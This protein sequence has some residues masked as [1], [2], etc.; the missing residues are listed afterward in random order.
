MI[1]ETGGLPHMAEAFLLSTE[2]IVAA[3]GGEVLRGTPAGAI[4]PSRF[5][6]DSRTAR[7]DSIFL[8]HR[9]EQA[10]AHDFIGPAVEAGCR[11]VMGED[12]DKM[13]AAAARHRGVLFVLV[14][15]AQAAAQRMARAF[16]ESVDIPVIAI[17][18]AC[19]KTTT[20]DLAGAILSSAVPALV[21]PVNHNNLWGVPLTLLELRA[22]HRVAVLELGTNTPGEI[23]RLAE[24][25]QPT[26]TY[27]TSIG[28]SH[29]MNF[30]SIEGVLAAETEH[31]EWLLEQGRSVTCLANIDDPILREFFGRK[32]AAL[33]KEGTLFRLSSAGDSQADVRITS[34][35]TLDARGNFGTRFA[36]TSPW[37]SGE[38]T[39]PV[40]GGHNVQNAL[41]AIALSMATG[42]ASPDA[43]A[44]A[45]AKPR[46]SP[47]RSEIRTLAS[48]VTLFNDCYN[49]NPLSCAAALATAGE[50]RG[51]PHSGVIRLIAVLGDMLELG[52]GAAR[53]HYETGRAAAL[54]GVDLLLST[55]EFSRQWTDGFRSEAD[56]DQAAQ[57]FENKNDLWAWLETELDAGEAGI[58]VLVKGSRG[59]GM[60]QVV[61]M[62]GRRNEKGGPSE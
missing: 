49:S 24:I 11:L 51:N 7:S 4:P 55:G 33:E 42:L 48:G 1:R 35:A 27:T 30:G 28:A 19:G 34:S 61:S 46:L 56:G 22:S 26:I 50:I 29:M 38:A 41:G 59:A 10:D 57:S 9:G 40:P 12:R 39:L 25:V 36:W 37:G 62:L 45:L 5:T 14:A 3:A 16:R 32:A 18:G 15:Q 21:T 43:V 47:L 54:A 6:L 60:D 13:Q 8:C 58:L 2:E 23:G 52:A 53:Y 17:T 44:G 31:I 20:K